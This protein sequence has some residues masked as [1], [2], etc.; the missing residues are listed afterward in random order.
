[1][2]TSSFTSLK[3]HFLI[4]MPK[5]AKSSFGSSLT[6]ICEHT[7]EGAF[8]IIVNRPTNLMLG[9]VLRQ[10]SLD[11]GY[12]DNIV[13]NIVYSGGPIAMGRGFVLNSNEKSWN[14]CLQICDG[15]QLTTSKDILVAI[16]KKQGPEHFLVALGY[17]GW[18]A[19]QLEQELADNAWLNCQADPA[20][21]FDIPIHLRLSQAASSMGVD[22][23]L[24]SDQIGHA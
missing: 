16:S 6:I 20:I 2:K 9:E 14:A 5:V 10:A 22:L 21:I 8:G 12:A 7:P 15:L 24:I 19:G 17:A 13:E 4:P 11:Q 1:M 18:G 23:A 3:S